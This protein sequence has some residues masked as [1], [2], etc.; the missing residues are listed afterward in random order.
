MIKNVLR[1]DSEISCTMSSSHKL[2]RP[3]EL[4]SSKW[5]V[6]IVLS[7]LFFSSIFCTQRC[8]WI[9]KWHQYQ[10]GNTCLVSWWINIVAQAEVPPTHLPPLTIMAEVD[11]QR[12]KLLGCRSRWGEILAGN[13]HEA[14]FWLCR[15]NH[16]VNL[17]WCAL[18]IITEVNHLWGDHQDELVKLNSYYHI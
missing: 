16:G 3:H 1:W 8:D 10:R 15:V 13:H 11:C 18:I 6:N 5:T 12:R 14:V 4:S 7:S 17:V 9:Q 2:W